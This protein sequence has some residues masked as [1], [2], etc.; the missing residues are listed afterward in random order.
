[1]TSDGELES[2]CSDSIFCNLEVVRGLFGQPVREVSLSVQVPG[3]SPS[4]RHAK[5]ISSVLKQESRDLHVQI[6]NTFSNGAILAIADEAGDG[7]R[8][9][10]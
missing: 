8:C 6:V 10:V 7:D 9:P 1:M 2:S 4:H 3:Y 5:T